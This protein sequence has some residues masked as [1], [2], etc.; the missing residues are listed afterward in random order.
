MDQPHL[1]NLGATGAGIGRQATMHHDRE[2]HGGRTADP[3]LG[4]LLELAGPMQNL[5]QIGQH[6]TLG[7]TRAEQQDARQRPML[8]EQRFGPLQLRMIGPGRQGLFG[9]D[10]VLHRLHDDRVQLRCLR[11]PKGQ[12]A[13]VAQLLQKGRGL[14]QTVPLGLVCVTQLLR[15]GIG[16]HFRPVA[17]NTRHGRVRWRI[18]LVL[19]TCEQRIAFN[20]C[21]GQCCH[22]V[23][24]VFVAS[25]VFQCRQPA[26]AHSNG[27][28][29]ANTA[30]DRV[31]TGKPATIWNA[32]NPA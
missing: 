10:E 9:M 17:D 31:S 3:V 24:P 4:A 32:I 21:G 11:A 20:V 25:C 5:G 18:G 28:P 27:I 23:S 2:D 16:R 19:Q 14:L 15:A 30:T 12:A 8:H 22:A 29:M 13:V 26:S 6:I 1:E 7:Q